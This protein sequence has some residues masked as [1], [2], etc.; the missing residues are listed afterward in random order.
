MYGSVDLGM[1]NVKEHITS[2]IENT[3]ESY[4]LDKQIQ[5]NIV[6]DKLVF[7]TKTLVPLVLIINEVIS[8]SLKYAFINRKGGEF[9]VLMKKLESNTFEMIIG[10]NGVGKTANEKKGLGSRL[11]KI[12]A[13]QLNGTIEELVQPGVVYKLIFENI[14]HT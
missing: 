7:G 1:I 4:A 2:L 11:I 5:L 13:K 9:F 8:N 6:I 10:D 3:V 12:F 14:D